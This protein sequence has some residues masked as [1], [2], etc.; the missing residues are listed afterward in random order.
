M[1]KNLEAKEEIKENRFSAINIVF[2]FF[3]VGAILFSSFNNSMEGLTKESFEAAKGAVNLAISLIGIMAFWLGLMRVLEASGLMYS[4]SKKIKPL[5]CKLFPEVPPTHPAM[6][7]MLLNMSSN[8]LGLGNAATPF[9]IKA[10]VELNKLNQFPGTLTNA[11]CLFLAINTSSV[12]IL[13]LGAIAVRGAS[14]ASEPSSIFLPT[15]ISTICSTLTAIFLASFL[16]KKDK[17]YIKML[18][19]KKENKALKKIKEEKEEE[20]KKEDYT[21][22]LVEPK[23]LYVFLANSFIFMFFAFGVYRLIISENPYMFFT[24]DILTHWL[25]PFLILFIV[26]YGLK[27]GVKIYEAVT[28]GAKQG[29]DIAV[30][31]I[32]Y[33]VSILV[34]I[35]MFRKSGAMDVLASVIS[36]ITNFIGMPA[37]VLPMA[38]LRPLSG[39][40]AFA[41]MS[42]LVNANPNS[43]SSFLASVMMGSTETTF[44]VLAVY[45]GAIGAC[46]IRHALI[47]ALLADTVGILVSCLSSSFYWQ[48]LR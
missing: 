47:A 25:M 35:S 37:D 42:A 1:S 9:G 26:S 29:F 16:A 23:P 45:C 10:M 6:S 43:Y 14:G 18:K 36:P 32:P 34:S 41:Y 28:E 5:M 31:I 44:Y 11:M 19:E 24:K 46:K 39:S 13:P 20:I 15:L 30:K 17:S 2:V 38:L 33:L 27:K 7:A 40:G 8:M 12:T 4:I 3:I 21:N 48:F 22:L